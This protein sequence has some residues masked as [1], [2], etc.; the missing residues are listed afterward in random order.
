[1]SAVS[2]R[3]WALAWTRSRIP[4]TKSA[5]KTRKTA[6]AAIQLRRERRG[7]G[8]TVDD[9]GSCACTEICSV[10][11][12]RIGIIPSKFISESPLCLGAGF[13]MSTLQSVQNA[14]N[15]RH[16]K[17]RGY[18]GEKQSADDCAAQRSVLF[19]TVP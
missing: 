16:E 2:V 6:K 13:S 15:S 12:D 7:V 14:E 10:V 18:R 17:Q 8:L 11:C 5:A 9:C 4:E 1:M 19:A 3:K